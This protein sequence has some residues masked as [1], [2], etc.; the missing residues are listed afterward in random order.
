MHA[1]RHHISNVK[2]QTAVLHCNCPVMAS[3]QAI[4]AVCMSLLL[5]SKRRHVC[6]QVGNQATV[7]GFV[8][9]PF[10]LASYIVEGGSSKSYTHIKRL[11]FSD[12]ETLHALL[13]K[14]AENITTYVQYQ[15]SFSLPT[16]MYE[17]SFSP[18]L[19]KH[20]RECSMHACCWNVLDKVMKIST[21]AQCSYC[22]LPAC[23]GWAKPHWP[24]GHRRMHSAILRRWLRRGC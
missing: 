21:P 1:C 8:G 5:H 14:L 9:A 15:V 7:L 24:G 16:A 10:T 2:L 6:V 3:H 17:S 20:H 23:T 12:P 11:A 4:C 13:S 22:M 19:L 18:V